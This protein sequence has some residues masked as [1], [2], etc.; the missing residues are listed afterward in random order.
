MY[1]LTSLRSNPGELVIEL[2]RTFRREML[3]P[4]IIWTGLL[5]LVLSANIGPWAFFLLLFCA[6]WFHCFYRNRVTLLYNAATLRVVTRRDLVFTQWHSQRIYNRADVPP[7]V[8]WVHGTPPGYRSFRPGDGIPVWVFR[9]ETRFP[10]LPMKTCGVICSH[11][12]EGRMLFLQ[13]TVD[14][15]LAETPYDKTLFE[16]TAA[17][18]ET[19][20]ATRK[21]LV[22]TQRREQERE[23]KRDAARFDSVKR[24]AFDRG[25]TAIRRGNEPVDK[26][27][28]V[29]PTKR[30]R[31]KSYDLRRRSMVKMEEEV[32]ADLTQ[33][34]LK[35]VSTTGGGFSYLMA[36]LSVLL[37]YASLLVLVVG[38]GLYLTMQI[39]RWEQIEQRLVP[40]VE[41]QVL[42]RLPEDAHEPVENAMQWYSDASRDRTHK[43]DAIIV[44]IVV[45]AALLL[46]F[47][48]FSRIVRWPFWKRWTVIVKNILPH[49]RCV[50]LCSWKTDRSHCRESEKKFRFYFRVIPATP[51]T[52]RLLTGRPFFSKNP[53]WKQR[54]QVVLIT[55]QGT[56][57]LPC[58]DTA[59]QEEMMDRIR[60]FTE[61]MESR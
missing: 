13:K 33:G 1:I 22:T 12:T 28:T 54:H 51:K 29:A 39:Y 50:L 46:I 21:T 19:Q 16:Q 5:F 32:S 31:N 61:G 52:N 56:F 60:R 15:F 23:Q 9:Y 24:Y 30:T 6:Y 45:W 26:G 59:E 41:Q 27:E 38:G 7:P 8:T 55:A 47:I 2:K 49:Q 20:Q 36:T 42:A 43:P 17:A 53:G 48:F 11:E 34:T 18:L 58:G 35:L 25:E 3:L 57:P 14:D 4:F 10:F 44:T 40:L 37:F